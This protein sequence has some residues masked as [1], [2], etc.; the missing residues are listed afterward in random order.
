M[1]RCSNAPVWGLYF[2]S[3]QSLKD[4]VQ[5]TNCTVRVIP[6]TDAAGVLLIWNIY[7]VQ[8]KMCWN[9]WRWNHSAFFQHHV[10]VLSCLCASGALPDL[11]KRKLCLVVSLARDLSADTLLRESVMLILMLALFSVLW[12]LYC[13]KLCQIINELLSFHRI[14]VSWCVLCFWLSMCLGPRIPFT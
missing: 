11:R 5:E 8:W 12:R 1:H 4:C 9:L 2:Q 6:A 13:P 7:C 10:C 3:S 14:C